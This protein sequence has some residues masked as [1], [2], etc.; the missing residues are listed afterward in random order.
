M[1]AKKTNP[2]SNTS[3]NL[4]VSYWKNSKLP[5]W[6]AAKADA[7][8]ALVYVNIKNNKSVLKKDLSAWLSDWQLEKVLNNKSQQIMELSGP[9]ASVWVLSPHINKKKQA[10][11]LEE[12]AISDLRN[13]VGLWYRQSA[14]DIKK[15][16]L[17]TSAKKEELYWILYGFLLA[18]YTSA[19]A[20]KNYQ[21]PSIKLNV[22]APVKGAAFSS[23]LKQVTAH[24]KGH[25]LSRHLTNLPPNQ[26][27]PKSFA[28]LAQS[29]FKADAGVKLE[30]WNAD[31][32]KKESCGLLYHVGLGSEHGSHLVRI[33]YRPKS[34]KKPLAFVGKGVT[35]DTGGL[36]IKP[37]DN[38]RLM[39][40][41]MSGA[42]VVLAL[43]YSCIKGKLKR[44]ADFYLAL[45]ENSVNEKATRPSD[46]HIS[47]AGYSVEIHNTD[48]EGRLAM[49]D[50]LTVASEKTGKDKP[51]AIIDVSTLTG[52][53]RISL[54]LDV[55]G[56][57]TNSDSLSKKLE[58][59][60]NKAGEM[61]W[62]QPLVP[63]YKRL[64]KSDIADMTNCGASSFGGAI[65]AALFLQHFVGD[66]QWAHFDV[67][68]WS[69]SPQGAFSEGGNGQSYLTL[70]ALLDS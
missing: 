63:S 48:A 10:G 37:A 9:K 27:N 34:S 49:A 66:A 35:F 19:Q 30:I 57:F 25:N 53:M 24:A 1:A 67:M 56:Y 23:L 17:I 31:R 14:K 12:N 38:M 4:Q 70:S 13:C 52:A 18:D 62:R 69:S 21:G 36:D 54:G 59:V 60:A 3:D 28:D 22:Q 55:A 68:A 43:A 15:L 44:P 7:N 64:F 61:V 45:T 40:K 33:S 6:S 46:V 51:E 2:K 5:D 32:L 26:L 8:S 20:L 65:T 11:S 42:G 39:K 29:L 47:R 16:S 58:S 41:D 50:A